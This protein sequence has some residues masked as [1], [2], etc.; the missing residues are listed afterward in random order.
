[1]QGGRGRKGREQEPQDRGVGLGHAAPVGGLIL[2]LLQV[3]DILVVAGPEGVLVQDEIFEVRTIAHLDCGGEG[4][5]SYVS[6]TW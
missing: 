3:A 1:M 4:L 6:A 5:G 2:P